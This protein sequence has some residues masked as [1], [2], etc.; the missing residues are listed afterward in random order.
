MGN[1]CAECCGGGSNKRELKRLM[2]KY[3]SDDKAED[4][5]RRLNRYK[6]ARNHN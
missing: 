1:N 5:M 2:D 3:Y 4:T 6:F